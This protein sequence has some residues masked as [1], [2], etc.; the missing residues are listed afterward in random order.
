MLGLST[1]QDEVIPWRQRFLRYLEIK[2]IVLFNTEIRRAIGN[3]S[4]LMPVVDWVIIPIVIEFQGLFNIIQSINLIK[5]PLATKIIL[6]LLH[7]YLILFKHR[8]LLGLGLG[9]LFF[10]PIFRAAFHKWLQLAAW[11]FGSQAC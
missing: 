2:L 8:F 1:I 6:R 9:K 5:K 10:H 7:S 4:F 3:L 11:L